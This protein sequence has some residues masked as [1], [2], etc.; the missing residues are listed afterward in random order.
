[1]AGFETVYAIHNFEAENDDE[2]AFSIGEPV[3]VLEKDDGYNDGWWQGRNIKGEIGL[4][5][6]NYTAPLGSEASLSNKTDSLQEVVSDMQVPSQLPTPS[7]SA[8]TGQSQ[9]SLP[10]TDSVSSLNSAPLQVSAAYKNVQRAVLASL[11][12][13]ALKT[14]SPDE[15]DVEQVALWLT[16]MGFET[17]ADNFKAQEITGDILV[18]LTLNSL[19]ELEVNTFGKRFKIR[20][21]ITALREELARQ[22]KLYR[23]SL[24][25]SSTMIT[26]EDMS[27]NHAYH[28]A[29]LRQSEYRWRSTRHLDSTHLSQKKRIHSEGP[30][31]YGAT[32]Q[33]TNMARA[34]S[35]S[36]GPPRNHSNKGAVKRRTYAGGFEARHSDFSSEEDYF[37]HSYL[38][39][40]RSQTVLPVAVRG[41]EDRMGASN[42]SITP[43]NEGWLHKQGDKYKTWNK[44]WF[45]LKGPN[46]FYFKSPKDVRMKGIIH[47]RGYRIV[48]DETIHPGKYC[49]KTQHDRERTFYFFTDTESSMKAWIKA[50]MKATISRDFTAPVLSSSSIPTVTLDIAQRMKPRPP[51]TLLY[52]KDQRIQSAHIPNPRSRRRHSYES[53]NTSTDQ[54]SSADW[55]MQEESGTIISS[56]NSLGDATHSSVSSEPKELKDSGFDC[57]ESQ[58]SSA[59]SRMVSAT[60][61]MDQSEEDPVAEEYEECRTRATPSNDGGSSFGVDQQEDFHS[62]MSMTSW[63][64][65][66][67]VE[68]I[69][70]IVQH[71]TLTHLSELRTGDI[72]IELLEILSGKEVRRPP[73][74]H[75]GPASM[76]MLDNIVAAFKFMNREGVDVE[77]RF[78][79]KDIFGGNEEKIMDMLKSIR[80]TYDSQEA[81][82]SIYE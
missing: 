40:S 12:L 57:T 78:T 56:E 65:S 42:E 82:E 5:P 23:R 59:S 17:V 73:S 48:V 68:W 9:D 38:S 6:V 11:S 3:I 61:T 70:C 31:N 19:K 8:S 50:L 25:S 4:F 71:D 77:R 72:L 30:L 63:T 46:L 67:Y 22:H 80:E 41:S 43:D 10:Y 39:D 49:F 24:R 13:P 34:Y 54:S 29:H 2:I 62:L 76:Q 15:W 16:T 60:S 58:R 75:N 26:S 18:E 1:M 66:H 36:A 35:T 27:V 20:T 53:Q 55:I 21:A 79:I 7:T 33:K 28:K 47:L 44:R 69:N 81:T 45:V 14:S 37:I 51:S 32:H 52:R 74:S 64:S